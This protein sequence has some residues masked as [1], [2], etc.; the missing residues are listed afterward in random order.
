MPKNTLI[1]RFSKREKSDNVV[2]RVCNAG[3]GESYGREEKNR[4]EGHGEVA[5]AEVE[6]H[7][8]MMP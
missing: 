1:S 3:Y 5:T 8:E 6:T 4:R 2:A 7:P